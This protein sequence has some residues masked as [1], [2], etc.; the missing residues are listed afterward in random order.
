MILLDMLVLATLTK[1]S[2]PNASTFMLN[3]SVKYLTA[4][5]HASR[6]PVMTVV[7]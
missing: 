1:Q 6:Y 3:C 7:G 5:L 2:L 4:S